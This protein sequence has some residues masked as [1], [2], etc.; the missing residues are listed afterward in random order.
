MP[1][2]VADPANHEM[3]FPS[4][5]SPNMEADI[6]IL[7][8]AAIGM[9]NLGNNGV[10]TSNQVDTSKATAAMKRQLLELESRCVL[11]SLLK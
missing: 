11:T 7:A 10:R 1:A 6:P 3:F 9:N 5:R 4:P 8:R 2:R